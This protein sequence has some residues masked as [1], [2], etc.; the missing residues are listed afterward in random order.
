MYEGSIGP[1]PH[2]EA[3]T[4]LFKAYTWGS[5]K[6]GL[7]RALSLGSRLL[8][9]HPSN[10]FMVVALSQFEKLQS[11]AY[12]TMHKWLCKNG[13]FLSSSGRQHESNEEVGESGYH[14]KRGEVLDECIQRIHADEAL[15]QYASS[16]AV[17]YMRLKKSY[18]WING[19]F[20][21][22]LDKYKKRLRLSTHDTG[23]SMNKQPIILIVEFLNQNHWQEKTS[24]WLLCGLI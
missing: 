16:L 7:S 13:Y 9:V 23:T 10:L 2:I 22:E 3:K 4:S 18:Q 24:C 8:D 21:A 12:V 1:E 11:A 19:A 14:V 20:N 15:Q 6:Y 17:V 5:T